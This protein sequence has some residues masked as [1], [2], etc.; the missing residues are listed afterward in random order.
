MTVEL[1]PITAADVPEVARFMQAELNPQ[2]D[3]TQ[4]AGALDVP[5]AVNAPNHG[6]LLRDEGKVVGAY[7]AYYSSRTIGG[8]TEQF[9][10]LGAWCVLES[11]RSH[12]LRLLRALLAQKGYHFT[13]LSP[14]GNV[15]PLN[16]RLKFHVLDTTTALVPN[17]P[18][19]TVPGRCSVTS[20]PSVL[21]ATLTG[22]DLQ[23]YRDHQLAAAARHVALLS[24]GEHC[25]VM[26][27]RDTRRGLRVF[28]TVLHVGNPALFH[29]Y[30]RHLSRHLLLHE[31]AAATLAELRVVGER[32][33]AAVT[34]KTSRPKMFKSPT[35]GPDD[36]DYLYSELTCLAW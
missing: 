33:P 2:V 8:R 11:H 6:F 4:W 20:D 14:S 13:D 3:A 18:W 26:Y 32:P 1:A 28:A 12:G 7:L 27:R 30:S 29:R 10:N 21:S 17:L 34:L 36:I 9:C 24:G 23:I 35:L 16:K 25:Y 22:D 31:G 15:V 5:W 19:P